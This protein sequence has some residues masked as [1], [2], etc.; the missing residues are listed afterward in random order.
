[1]RCTTLYHSIYQP[2]MI[3]NEVTQWFS[4]IMTQRLNGNS[5]TRNFIPP[6]RS[7]HRILTWIYGLV[8]SQS[9]SSKRH[10]ASVA[11]SQEPIPSLMSSAIPSSFPKNLARKIGLGVGVPVGCILL[12]AALLYLIYPRRKQHRRHEECCRH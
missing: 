8:T 2:P 12:G 10:L 3:Y 1:M 9:P 4:Y 5:S 11:E 6:V 7:T